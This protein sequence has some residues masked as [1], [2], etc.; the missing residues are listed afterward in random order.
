MSQEKESKQILGPSI[1]T[2]FERAR[3][4]GAR[5][6]QISMGA[7]PLIETSLGT[8]LEIAEEELKSG[9]LPITIRRRLPDGRHQDIPIKWLV[10]NQ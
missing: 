8:P 6:L 10:K 7:P 1:L 4:L 5:S 2:R 3:V 9:A